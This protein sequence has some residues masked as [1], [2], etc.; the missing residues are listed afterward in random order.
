MQSG[1][2]AMNEVYI[3]RLAKFLP[4][5]PVP[6]DEMEAILGMIDGQP[7][8][9]RKIILRQ[10]GIK[11]R[12]Y[13]V[14]RHGR[15]THNNAQLAAE[16]IRRLTDEHFTLQNIEVLCCGTSS[17]D[18]LIPSHASMVH[19]VLKNRPLEINSPSGVCCS[20]MQAFKYGYLSVASGNSWNAVCSGS[21][22][23]S[24]GLCAYKFSTRLG[25]AG[26][27]ERQHAPAFERDLLRWMLSDG[28]GALLMQD[29]P[30]GKTC[31]RVEW[32]ESHSFASELDVCMFAGCQR[33]PDGTVKSVHQFDYD[34]VVRESLLTLQQDVKLLNEN[35]VSY[36]VRSI[37]MAAA[38]R[39][40][41]PSDVDYFVPHLSSYYFRP[42]LA[43]QM[44]AS[45]MGIVPEKWFTNLDRVGNV[46]SAS[47]YLALEELFNSGRLQKGQLIWLAVPESGRF[48]YV[49]ALLTV[50]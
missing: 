30:A 35:I 5:E 50:C 22:T 12:H 47:S 9:L 19:G 1:T 33:Q 13:V 4:N 21:E 20:G 49:Q 8:R 43:E 39:K 7:S 10:N 32:V 14:D 18:Q 24:L 3:T 46:G 17:P 38:K 15:V 29:T 25:T 37:A 40:I 48:M 41:R 34:T 11:S 44:E 16:A 2:E 31:L 23:S 28:A 26:A 45:G 27:S 6:N 42:S 36:G